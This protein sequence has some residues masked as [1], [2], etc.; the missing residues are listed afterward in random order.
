[1][2][3]KKKVSGAKTKGKFASDDFVKLDTRFTA[4]KPEVELLEKEPK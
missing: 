2:L 1:L 3:G 4:L